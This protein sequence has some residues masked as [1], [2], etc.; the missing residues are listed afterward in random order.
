VTVGRKA[1]V[2]GV[3]FVR[4]V[5]PGH[6]A[7][8][9]LLPFVRRPGKLLLDPK[10][11]GLTRGQRHLPRRRGAGRRDDPN[12]LRL[13]RLDHVDRRLGDAAD[14]RVV[15]RAEFERPDRTQTD[16]RR[17][18][19]TD[20]P[21]FGHGVADARA[22]QRGPL[23]LA[24]VLND[25]IQLQPGDFIHGHR[26]FLRLEDQA[27][28]ARLVDGQPLLGRL[29]GRRVRAD[30]IDPA[31][32]HGPKR[33]GL[34]GDRQHVGVGTL[35]LGQLGHQ[36]DVALRTAGRQTHLARLSGQ[37]DRPV[38]LQPQLD[39]GVGRRRGE[40]HRFRLTVEVAAED[41]QR[42]GPRLQGRHA[43]APQLEARLGVGRRAAAEAEPIAE[44]LHSP[45]AAVSGPTG[46]PRL[47]TMRQGDRP[48]R[49]QRQ[50]ERG[51]DHPHRR[52][53]P[54]LPE[55]QRQR[56]RRRAGAGR[57]HAVQFERVRVEIGIAG[58]GFLLDGDP[59]RRDLDPPIRFLPFPPDHRHQL[60]PDRV[61]D[62]HHD[63]RRIDGHR[64][65]LR[66][67]DGHRDRLGSLLAGLS[68]R[69][70]SFSHRAADQPIVFRNLH[71]V[72]IAAG[73]A[74]GR[75]AGRED[76]QVGDLAHYH[77]QRAGIN[78]QP[79]DA[80]RGHDAE[81]AFAGEV[82]VEGH[83]QRAGADLAARQPPPFHVSDVRRRHARIQQRGLQ[84]RVPLACFRDRVDLQRA[85]AI[86][87]HF[88]GI[89]HHGQ[90]R[91]RDLLDGHLGRSDKRIALGV[92]PVAGRDGRRALGQTFQKPVSRVDRP[93]V[94]RLPRGGVGQV[95][96][97]SVFVLPDELQ[98]CGRAD[99]QLDLAGFDG[100]RIRRRRH[101]ADQI[102]VDRVHAV[103][104]V[105]TD[106]GRA[107]AEEGRRTGRVVESGHARVENRADHLVRDVLLREQPGT[108][109]VELHPAAYRTG[110]CF[111]R[112]DQPVGVG[113]PII[114]AGQQ[115]QQQQGQKDLALSPPL[116]LDR[117]QG[118]TRLAAWAL[119]ALPGATHE[120]QGTFGIGTDDRRG[121]FL[122]HP[123]IAPAPYQP[124]TSLHVA[125]AEKVAVEVRPVGIFGQLLERAADHLFDHPLGGRFRL[126]L[127][128]AVLERGEILLEE[129]V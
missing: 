8:T 5:H 121:R 39:A 94:K 63:R 88:A 1:S 22:D 64:E 116:L 10:R 71:D 3:Q 55:S 19:E 68:D 106:L 110:M 127:F 70:L 66:R 72:R 104:Q 122:I 91:E 4:N 112:G 32:N 100:D 9:D 31:G 78:G 92:G 73:H 16:Q 58:R 113:P 42:S 125:I 52:R 105:E 114:E 25:Q 26:D 67:R 6:R 81:L 107:R 30:H 86:Q 101:R 96:F 20:G 85:G 60:R 40:I 89:D 115:Q 62:R 37:A 75:T 53:R 35:V 98:P 90:R 118:Q 23:R 129:A 50:T 27:R 18:R 84:H 2:A 83:R 12:G 49:R 34:L 93:I 41:E 21:R 14:V 82:L 24:A 80:G 74:H 28:L 15:A 44:H 108:G 7:G 46:K 123:L 99:A 11:H 111:G 33:P 59:V 109:D 51:H 120:Q 48:G 97:G 79:I 29:L 54:V 56:L 124:P 87:A 43:V 103:A 38:H 36:L 119:V 95:D 126:G 117:S 65:N 77:L 128:D 102:H 61:I 57:H 45:A 13:G 69:D 76:V 17:R 47:L